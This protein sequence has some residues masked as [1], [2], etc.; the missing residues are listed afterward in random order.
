MSRSPS[1]MVED[2]IRTPAPSLP[3]RVP[4]MF[5][6]RPSLP[7]RRRRPSLPPPSPLPVRHAREAPP[8]QDASG[9]SPSSSANQ[10]PHLIFPQGGHADFRGRNGTCYNFFSA[11]GISLSIRTED[12]TFTLFG[13]KLV[14]DGSFITEAR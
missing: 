7:P 9:N 8:G 4:R 10:D 6:I 5:F 14:V 11:P 13:G 2:R 1:A 3:P 12:A